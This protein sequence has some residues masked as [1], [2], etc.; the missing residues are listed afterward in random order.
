MTIFKFLNLFSG[1][2]VTTILNNIKHPYRIIGI[3]AFGLFGI[4]CTEIG[5]IGILP[6]IA[7]NFHIGM[8]KAGILISVFAMTVAIAGPFMTLLFSHLNQKRILY[9]SMIIFVISNFVSVIT[10]NFTL[11]FIARIFPAFFHPI[12]ISVALSIAQKCLPPEK[13]AKASSLVFMGFTIAMVFGIPFSAFLSNALSFRW[14]FV[15]YLSVN[16][17]ASLLILLSFPPFPDPL[18]ISFREQFAILKKPEVWFNIFTSC[19]LVA[20]MFATY[21]YFSTYLENISHMNALEISIMLTVFGFTGVLGNNKIGN[22]VTPSN[23]RKSMFYYILAFIVL[24]IA[25]FYLSSF[26]MMMMVIVT[27]WGA[28]QNGGIPISQLWCTH[29]ALEAPEFSNSL[30]VSFSNWGITIGSFIGGIVLT[31]FGLLALNIMGII[32]FVIAMAFYFLSILVVK[33]KIS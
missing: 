12:Y 31:H 7:R 25:I 2:F 28:V 14:A 15:F 6:S 32:F 27:I 5:L 13:R 19:F 26:T 10:P 9:G 29:N 1:V 22:V 17:C 21:S 18:K 11:L 30:F 23:L 16:F 33:Q 20:G 4:I 3:L 8:D 24:Y